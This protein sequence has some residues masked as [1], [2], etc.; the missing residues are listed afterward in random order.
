MTKSKKILYASLSAAILAIIVLLAMFPERYAKCCLS[1]LELWLYFVLPS[2]FPFFVLTALLTK[3][4]VAERASRVLSPL[5]EKAFKMPGIASY[6]FAMSALSGYPVGSRMLADLRENGLITDAQATRMSPLCSTSGPLFVIASVGAAMFHS[7]KIGL[8]LFC[9]HIFAVVLVCLVF[10]AFTK[11]QPAAQPPQRR[12][13]AADNILYES[14]Y[15]A[16]TSILVVGAFIAVFYILAQILSDFYLLLPA[17]SLF[18]ARFIALRQ[19]RTTR[20]RLYAG[21]HR[22]DAR[23]QTAGAESRNA[24]RFPR[25]IRHYIRRRIH[26]RPADLLFQKSGRQTQIFSAR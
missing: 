2:L 21:A 8:I 6:C 17:E 20:R 14:V 4:G 10:S 9:S 3:L 15:G 23:L 19:E 16:V 12:L 22:G 24:V 1:G 25:R 5:C 7:Q 18:S 26:S 11:K 13:V